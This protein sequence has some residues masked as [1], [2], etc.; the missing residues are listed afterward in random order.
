M[1]VQLWVTVFSLFELACILS[2]GDICCG[3]HGSFMGQKRKD[4]LELS[5]LSLNYLE[6]EEEKNISRF[7]SHFIGGERCLLKIF[8]F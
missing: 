4:G 1:V 8:A 7:I 5:M 6:R 3:W 2:S